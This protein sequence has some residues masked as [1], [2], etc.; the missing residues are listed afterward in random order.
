MMIRRTMLSHPTRRRLLLAAAAICLAAVPPTFLLPHGWTPADFSRIEPGMS[1]A[2]VERILGPPGVSLT[3]N[4]RVEDPSTFVTNADPEVQRRLRHRD[5]Q[6]AGWE[7][8][9]LLEARAASVIFDG[10][11]VIC[12]YISTSRPDGYWQRILQRLRSQF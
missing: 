6:Y 9:G 10:D 2:E 11:R 3:M 5:Y 12:R 7:R 8:I 4:G 1:R